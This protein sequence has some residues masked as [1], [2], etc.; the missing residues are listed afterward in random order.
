MMSSDFEW[1]F[2]DEWFHVFNHCFDIREAKVIID[3]T[4]REVESV[5]VESMRSVLG[6]METELRDDLDLSFPMIF[7]T[8][9]FDGR[10]THFPIDGWHR[11]RWAA[12]NGLEELPCVVLTEAET[13]LIRR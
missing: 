6:F 10:L 9:H 11:V 3:R 2:D 4:P 7:A 5:S 12:E 8:L 1:V 13:T